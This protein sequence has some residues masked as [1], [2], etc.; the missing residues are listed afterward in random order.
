MLSA[1]PP[2]CACGDLVLSKLLHDNVASKVLL[3]VAC[4]KSEYSTCSSIL[5]ALVHRLLSIFLYEH[6]K[7]ERNRDKATLLLVYT[8]WIQLQICLLRKGQWLTYVYN[9]LWEEC[10]SA[11]IDVYRQLVL[12]GRKK[13]VGG[14]TAV[15]PL[16]QQK[17][18][19]DH[20]HH[21]NSAWACMAR[22]C[23]TCCKYA[24][25]CMLMFV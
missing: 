4:I 14:K 20:L 23:T 21:I 9:V 2:V 22:V 5:L 13:V 17:Y 15:W 19:C 11:S 25:A 24:R 18:W 1:C 12:K 6:W 16:N 10:I 7:T 8:Q 3:Q